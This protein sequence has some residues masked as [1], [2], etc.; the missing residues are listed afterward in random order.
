MYLQNAR[1]YIS[2]L[3]MLMVA[4]CGGG[5]SS[6]GVNAESVAAAS[7][8]PSG[9]QAVPARDLPSQYTQ[10][11][12][13]PNTAADSVGGS[14]P[15]EANLTLP[16]NSAIVST[17]GVD[18]IELSTVPQIYLSPSPAVPIATAPAVFSGYVYVSKEGSD[19]NGDGS[20]SKPY[21]SLYKASTVANWGKT[22][23]V[24]SGTYFET[25]PSRLLPGVSIEGAGQDLTIFQ[26]TGV[27]LSPGV[28][29]S[30]T[31]FKL[32]PEG[33]LIQL[34]SQT[35]NSPTQT[36]GD[37]SQMIAAADGRQTLSGFTINGSD[38]S[39]KAGVWVQNRNNVTM[40]HVS[41]INLKQRGA[42][43][44]RSNMDWYV[45]LP[46]AMWMRNTSIHDCVF[47]NSGADLSDESL[48]NLNIGGLDGASI[49]NIKIDEDKGYGIK[50][51]YVGHFR[52]VKI[53]NAE[54]KV[55]ETDSL[56]TEDSTIELWNLSRGN[57]IFNVNCNTW[58][59]IVNHPNMYD[60]VT[61]AKSNLWIHH[62]RMIDADG[63]SGKEAIEVGTPGM[64][65]SDSYFQDKGF[66][67]AVWMQGKNHITIAKN[68]ITRPRNSGHSWAADAGVFVPDTTTNLNIYNNVFDRAGI[69]IRMTGTISNVNIKNNL[70]LNTADQEVYSVT[71]NYSFSNN[72]KFN[73]N[74]SGWRLQNNV[75]NSSNLVHSPELLMSG[76]GWANYYRPASTSSFVVNRGVNVGLTFAGS[77][78]DIGRW[79]SK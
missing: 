20:S 77:A 54:I 31:N 33:A 79:E 9:Q 78:P 8:P 61:T 11:V 57:E 18:A 25:K 58:F 26:S 35:F 30:D 40:H 68:I 64:T 15:V 37:P 72:L 41:F 67:M 6:K 73:T 74:N 10:Q 32:S 75:A 21:A 2:I 55:P 63:V 27:E 3:M 5:Q 69:A 34:L 65:V 19:L 17:P 12:T 42:V 36:T 48:G 62:V 29:A 22:I 70:M 16:S 13:V 71:N 44:A 24:A 14:T 49:Y 56:W 45:P 1:A 52:N 4:A 7:A 43:F 46:D 51:I 59:S 39:L 50:Y 47:T 53:W 23:K 38:K 60:N 28:T 76:D 66:G